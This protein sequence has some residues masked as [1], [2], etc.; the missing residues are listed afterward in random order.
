MNKIQNPR[1][2]QLS[3][4]L[5]RT[6]TAGVETRIDGIEYFIA[7]SFI[8]HGYGSRCCCWEIS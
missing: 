5:V 6:K 8:N 3:K 2:A 1:Y 4:I 7:H